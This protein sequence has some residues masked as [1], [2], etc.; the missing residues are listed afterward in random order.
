M[1]MS[2]FHPRRRAMVPPSPRTTSSVIASPAVILVLNTLTYCEGEGCEDENCEG[3]ECEGERGSEDDKDEDDSSSN[4]C[5]VGD[6]IKV[7]GDS[8]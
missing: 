6:T 7:T 4:S 3:D 5:G 1:L 2:F 8:K